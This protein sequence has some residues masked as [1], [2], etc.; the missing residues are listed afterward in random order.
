MPETLPT[1][2]ARAW[3]TA[4]TCALTV[5]GASAANVRAQQPAARAADASYNVRS[6]IVRFADPNLK[7]VRIVRVTPPAALALPGDPKIEI[8]SFGSGRAESVTVVRGVPPNT[9]STAGSAPIGTPRL[10][11]QRI[12]GVTIVR[13]GSSRNDDFA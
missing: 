7:P 13:G 11:S 4:V 9:I 10:V 1:R 3:A 6:Q 2:C 8:V 5:Y 12:N